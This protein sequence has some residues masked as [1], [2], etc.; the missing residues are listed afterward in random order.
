MKSAKNKYNFEQNSPHG[1]FGFEAFK[2]EK[3][4]KYYFHFNGQVGHT[5]LFSQ[6]YASARSRDNGLNS[7]LSN[8]TDLNRFSFYTTDGKHYFTL[9]AGNNQEIAR[10]QL[11]DNKGE[12]EAAMASVIQYASVKNKS[13]DTDQDIDKQGI[14]GLPENQMES[15]PELAKTSNRVA[16]TKSRITI[17]FYRKKEGEP[18]KGRI[19]H[20][21]SSSIVKFQGYDRNVILSFIEQHLPTGEKQDRSIQAQFQAQIEETLSGIH[22]L[23]KGLNTQF[24][25][26][27]TPFKVGIPLPSEAQKFAIGNLEVYAKLIGQSQIEALGKETIALSESTELLYAVENN[28]LPVGTYRLLI[29]LYLSMEQEQKA[30]KLQGSCL[31]LVQ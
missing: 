30:K 18:V 22:T 13:A 14:G 2:N 31:L 6:A 1:K 24:I 26:S 4:N 19:E 9:L 7:V 11:F 27:G 10:S 8:A 20:P 15:S 23:N 5:L 3:E 21:L 25:Q 16:Q 17:E 28:V 12:M 29:H